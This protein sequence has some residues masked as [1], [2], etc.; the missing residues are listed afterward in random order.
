MFPVFFPAVLQRILRG[1][2]VWGWDWT[3]GRCE[4]ILAYPRGTCSDGSRVE[5][6]LCSFPRRQACGDHVRSACDS[7]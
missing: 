2:R 4:G 1:K 5:R 6:E 3:G 7:P